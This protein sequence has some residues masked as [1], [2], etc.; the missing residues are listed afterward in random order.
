MS[1]WHSYPK[2][3]ALGHAAIDGMLQDEVIVE[4]KI[5]GSQFSFGLIDGELKIRSKNEQMS[6]KEGTIQKMFADGV[7]T[8]CDIESSLTPGW[9]YRA[10][11]LKTP[12]HNALTYE[13]IPARHLIVF[14]VNTGEERYLP[15]DEKRAEA[16]RLGL[17][18][19]PLLYRGS[20]SDPSSLLD[21]MGQTSVLGG[22]KIEGFVVKNYS[23]FGRD[24]KAML[25]KFVSEEF[26]ETNKVGWQ[27]DNPKSGDIIEILCQKYRA[28]P[29][30]A[31]AVQHLR[32]GGKIEGDPRDIGSL[33]T[34][35]RRDVEDECVDEIKAALWKWAKDHIL[36]RSTAGLPEWYK[37]TLL[38]RQS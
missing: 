8:V 17:E 29:R 28:E 30:W 14:D 37:K 18:C 22:A 5:D 2:V 25:G 10:E 12:R 27:K 1:S 20:V 6:V 15:Y 19:V 38:E 36:R 11:Y 9:T 3:Y 4:E 33:I 13:R 7:A 32:D 26:K 21:L 24:G 16:E 34:E 23:R 31:K 35:V